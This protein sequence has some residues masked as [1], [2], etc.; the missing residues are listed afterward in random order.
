MADNRKVA[1]V[2]GAA[3][4]I[5]AALVEAF[6]KRGYDVVANSRHIAKANPFATSASLALVDGDIGDPTTAAKIVDTTVSRFAR[7]DVLINNAGIFIPK[8]FTEYTTE[9][10]DALVS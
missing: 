4:G 9:D 8:A 1:I 2:T 3:Q 6:L 5:G 7:I 10:F